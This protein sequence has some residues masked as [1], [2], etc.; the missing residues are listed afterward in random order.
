[1]TAKKPKRQAAMPSTTRVSPTP[2]RAVRVGPLATIADVATEAA[3]LYRGARQ[4]RV[5]VGD[6]ARLGYLLGVIRGC[7]EVASLEQRIE[8]LETLERNAHVE[9]PTRSHFAA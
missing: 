1:M 9:E 2:R 3:R 4:G 5:P 7:L 6:A 8:R